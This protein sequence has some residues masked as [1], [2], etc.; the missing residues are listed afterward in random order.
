MLFQ[1][2]YA[3]GVLP[4][5]VSTP[6]S[7]NRVLHEILPSYRFYGSRVSDPRSRCQ[8]FG[9]NPFLGL[10]SLRFFPLTTYTVAGILP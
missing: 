7:S 1:S 4:Y 8:P 3:P 6:S 9:G 10:R 2:D 5:K